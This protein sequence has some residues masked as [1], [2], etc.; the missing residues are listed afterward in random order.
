MEIK[1]VKLPVQ[2]QRA[3]AAEAEAA[4]EARAKVRTSAWG[5]NLG[6]PKLEIHHS[7]SSPCRYKKV[8]LEGESIF[9]YLWGVPL[10]LRGSA[11]RN[12]KA[13]ED[14]I[15]ACIAFSRPDA[16]FCDPAFWMG[17]HQALGPGEQTGVAYAW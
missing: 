11:G 15:N 9:S 2:L 10:V 14:R 8:Q 7:L 13:F 4:R 17:G 3:M 5:L 16:S 6:F 12:T 1:D